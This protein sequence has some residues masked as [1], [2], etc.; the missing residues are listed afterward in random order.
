M[1][2]RRFP[3]PW[4][5]ERIVGGYVVKDANGQSLAYV[6]GRESRAD[7]DKAQLFTLDEARRIATNIAKLP[8]FLM[9]QLLND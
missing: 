1:T 9:A 6:Y 8:S 2:Q 3:P 4:K 7:A 5:I